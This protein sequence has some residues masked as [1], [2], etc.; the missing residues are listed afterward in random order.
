MY[1]PTFFF[2]DRLRDVAMATN[3][4]EKSEKLAY[5]T[6]IRRTGITK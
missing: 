1:D 2:I 4:V 6:F 3:F 5:R